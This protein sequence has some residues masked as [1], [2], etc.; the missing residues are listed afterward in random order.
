MEGV[1]LRKAT[2]ADAAQILDLVNGLAAD[3]V[4]LARSPAWVIENIRDFVIAEAGGEFA[5]CGALHVVWSHIAEIR[6]I[7]VVDQQRKTGLGRRMVDH[8]IAEAEALGIARVFAFTYV[9]GFFQGLGFE[10]VEHASLPHKV[11]QDCL[12]CPKFQKCDEVAVERVLRDT[13]NDPDRGPLSRP[14]S[15][16]PL[17]IIGR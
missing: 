17:P 5:G 6:S 2:T 16:V 10:L 1:T 4:M 8:M 12:N 14:F 3:Q 11:F 7:A 13:S 15:G 9:P